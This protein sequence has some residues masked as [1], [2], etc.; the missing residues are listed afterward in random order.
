MRPPLWPIMLA[1]PS[2]DMRGAKQKAQEVVAVGEHMA[3]HGQRRCGKKMSI[4][5]LLHS[6]MAHCSILSFR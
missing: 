5:D 4:R 1:T 6:Q 3:Q 2:S